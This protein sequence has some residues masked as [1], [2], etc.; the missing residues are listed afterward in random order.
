MNNLAACRAKNENEGIA[1]DMSYS[2]AHHHNQL[3][4]E[5]YHLW[6]NQQ[7][8]ELALL[9]VSNY[10]KHQAASEEMRVATQ[11]MQA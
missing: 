1:D 3:G 5:Q 8:Q 4:Q 2:I 7:L 6:L 11:R 9:S 10:I